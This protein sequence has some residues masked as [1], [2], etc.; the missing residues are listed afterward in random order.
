MRAMLYPVANIGRILF[1]CRLSEKK[2]DMDDVLLVNTILR[3]NLTFERGENKKKAYKKGTSQVHL[4]V[5]KIKQ[6]QYRLYI[7]RG[8]FLKDHTAIHAAL[9]EGLPDSRGVVGAIATGGN[10][11]RLV[12]GCLRSYQGQ[13]KQEG[14]KY[15]HDRNWCEYVWVRNTRQAVDPRAFRAVS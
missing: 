10:N 7:V 15:P 2:K 8:V 12:P 9:L 3:F 6:L 13:G 11:A 5:A 1:F 14:M 4:N